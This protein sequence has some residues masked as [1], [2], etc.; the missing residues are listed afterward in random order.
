MCCRIHEYIYYEEQLYISVMKV[1]Q[2]CNTVQC[3]EQFDNSKIILQK[4]PWNWTPTYKFCELFTDK[5]NNG[6]RACLTNKLQ[7]VPYSKFPMHV[8]SSCSKAISIILFEKCCMVW[9]KITHINSYWKK[10]HAGIFV[11]SEINFSTMRDSH[12]SSQLI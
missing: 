5:L 10:T 8:S 6:T 4:T 7:I 3:S 1:P 9:Y 2:Y 12:K 11:S